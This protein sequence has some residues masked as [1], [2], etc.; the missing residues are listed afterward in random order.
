MSIKTLHPIDSFGIAKVS[1]DSI[2]VDQLEG[3]VAPKVAF[4]HK[5]DFFQIL[6]ITHGGGTHQIDFHHFKIRP[7]QIHIIQPGQTHSW[8][9]GPGIRGFVL[10]F[11]RHSLDELIDRIENLEEL[12]LLKNKRDVKDLKTLC[13][14]MVAESQRAL[15]YFDLCLKGF[16]LGFLGRL[17][18]LLEPEK[19]PSPKT[20]SFLDEFRSLL[21]ENFKQEH[22]VEFYA[23]KMGLTA[24]VLTMR[25][26]RL[27]DR[28]P[29][30]LIQERC[31][32]E[33]KRYLAFS[34][35]NVSEVGAEIGF[36]DPNYFIRFFRNQEKQ[37][38]AQFR[39]NFTGYSESI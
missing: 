29:R 20:L 2:R 16:L 4:P 39:K 31:L 10:E 17:I 9:L 33:A 34:D 38:P 23:R 18:R 27:L 14:I 35:L 5:H 28:S 12:Y 15:P 3:R 7:H 36:Q 25:M 19:H 30:E 26:S 1:L 21:E 13:E 22:S 37:T 11:N 6:F 32:L 8:K 24:K